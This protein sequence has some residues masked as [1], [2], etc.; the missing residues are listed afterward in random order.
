MAI[1]MCLF[2]FFVGYWVTCSNL[3]HAPN[4][5]STIF[6]NKRKNSRFR[7]LKFEGISLASSIA[8]WQESSKKRPEQLPVPAFDLSAQGRVIA[9]R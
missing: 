7:T 2:G 4:Q 8:G 9:L 3:Y 6:L 1:I 5:V